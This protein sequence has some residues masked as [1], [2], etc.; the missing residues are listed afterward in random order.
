MKPQDIGLALTVAVIW[1]CNFVFAKY[2][3]MHFGAL[4]TMGIRL[5]LVGALIIPFTK[6]PRI[7]KK[8]MFKIS[9]I[10]GVLHHGFI[11]TAI[12][13]TLTI[14]TIVVLNQLNVPFSSILA[15]I[16]LK[17]KIKMRRFFGILISFIGIFIVFGVPEVSKEN[18]I[19]IFCV[20]MGA[21]T[22][23]ITNIEI[24]KLGNFDALPFL[25]WVSLMASP[26]LILLSLII[27]PF[28]IESFQIISL[29]VYLSFGYM[30]I[31][32]IIGYGIWFSLLQKYSVN[33]MAPFTL[34]T[35][36]FGMIAAAGIL[37]E[38]ITQELILGALITLIGVAI[39]T[40]RRPEY[41]NQ[42]EV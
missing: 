28:R 17:D 36:V 38:K 35:P 3:I 22:M 34:L 12:G 40:I 23:A 39:I 29:K 37:K 31:S 7:P 10:N 16:L 21:L 41:I 15:Y 33:L 2:A 26:F 8:D 1:G 30:M 19:A 18:L 27:E 20:I 13:S 32:S 11:F 14:G 9:F 42:Q 5:A 6:V 24:K 4:M 25:G